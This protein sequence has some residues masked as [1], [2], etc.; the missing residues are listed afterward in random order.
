[1]F[2]AKF[3]LTRTP[4]PPT[5][6]LSQVPRNSSSPVSKVAFSGRYLLVS[7]SPMT[8]YLIF[9]ARIIKSSMEASDAGVRALKF[10]QGDLGLGPFTRDYYLDRE[11][12]GEK[13]A[14]YRKFLIDK[15]T[16]FLQD[17]DLPNNGTKIANDV[18]EI[19]DLET[20]LAKIIV[21]E[22]DRRDF[23]RMYN[24][25]RLSDMQKLVPLVGFFCLLI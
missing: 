11:K 21:P 22:E 10:D 24:L 15:V 16:Q 19:I 25:R 17:I 2:M 8:S 12:H 3:V 20:K 9:L 5:P 1:M 7:V 13:I 14:A 6:L 18:D 4:T 23:N